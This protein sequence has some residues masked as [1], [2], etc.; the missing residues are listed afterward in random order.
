MRLS[1]F[2]LATACCL[3]GYLF[4]DLSEDAASASALSGVTALSESPSDRIL[5]PLVMANGAVF[6]YHLHF[7]DADTQLWGF[8]NGNRLGLGHGGFGVS[9]M[10]HP[11]YNWRDHYLSYALGYQDFALGYTQHLLY[12]SFSTGETYYSWQG[13]LGIAFGSGDYGSEVR[14][15]R[16]GTE[17]AQW[18]FT[19]ITRLTDYS[20]VA[21]D[22]VYQMHGK[23][24]VRAASSIWVG[25]ILLLQTSWQSEAPRFGFGVK[26]MLPHGSIMYAIRTHPELDLS[27]SLEIGFAW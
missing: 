11:D 6:C 27:Q 5:S 10:G 18:H 15:L 22:Y 9:W 23:D 4:A 14:W 7:H 24:S 13:D 12:E 2:I 17:D 20:S 1:L 3:G 19:A 21:T 25:K 16:I 26:L 8:H